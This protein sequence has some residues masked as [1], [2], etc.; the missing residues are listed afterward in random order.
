MDDVQAQLN[1]ESDL[2]KLEDEIRERGW[3]IEPLP[4][5]SVEFL[6]TMKSKVDAASYTFRIIGKNYPNAAPSIR[7]VNPTT[8][9]P[10]DP[11]AWPRC[12]GFRPPPTSDLCL[13]ISSEGFETHKE[14]AN[15]SRYAWNPTGNPIWFVL[16]AL[17]DKLNDRSK[18]QGRNTA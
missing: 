11:A 2:G 18:Y 5:T 1:L 16:S 13:A 7:C 4:I 17:Q 8:H 10:D 6:V 9:S 15:D 14:W 3:V 12:A